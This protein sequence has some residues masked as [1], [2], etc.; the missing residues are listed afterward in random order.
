[1]YLCHMTLVWA[2]KILEH[3][4]F[5]LILSKGIPALPSQNYRQ[6]CLQTAHISAVSQLEALVHFECKFPLQLRIWGKSCERKQV[7]KC[8][9]L[10]RRKQAG[11][12]RQQWWHLRNFA[13]LHCFSLSSCIH[14]HMSLVRVCSYYWLVIQVQMRKT[15]LIFIY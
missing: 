3:I 2:F 6:G 4:S 13:I 1:M 11:R 7:G 12:L 8:L 9:Q 14:T 10:D 15:P 5:W